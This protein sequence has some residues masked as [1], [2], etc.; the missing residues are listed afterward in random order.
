MISPQIPPITRAAV[1]LYDLRN[2]MMEIRS[3][4]P[5]Y[6]PGRE[7]SAYDNCKDILD[8]TDHNIRM[9]A[10]YLGVNLDASDSSY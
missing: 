3:T 2:A 4:H 9:L 6:M 5:S 1:A 7:P 8:L 10:V